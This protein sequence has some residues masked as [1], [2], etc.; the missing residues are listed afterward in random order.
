MLQFQGDLLDSDNHSGQRY[1]PIMD[2]EIPGCSH[3]V[4]T[5]P[6]AVQGHV[7]W[8]SLVSFSPMQR[9]R[10]GYRGIVPKTTGGAMRVSPRYG[11][12]P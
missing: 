12:R 1:T 11:Y 8:H 3:T 4:G 9:C 2:I 10:A 5:P 7:V 6:E